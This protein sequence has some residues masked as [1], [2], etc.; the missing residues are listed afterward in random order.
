M[1]QKLHGGKLLFELLKR[2]R[3]CEWIEFKLS[4][5]KPDEIGEYC[6]ALSNAALFHDQPYSYLIFGL[7]DSDLKVLGTAFK[8]LKRKSATKSWRIGLQPS[9]TLESIS[10]FLNLT[11]RTT[12][13]S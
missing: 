6:S 12:L 8:Q 10:Y 11:M 4:D 2:G 13:L 7:S 5:C 9:L 1:N 3:E